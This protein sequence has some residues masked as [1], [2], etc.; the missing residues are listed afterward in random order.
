M[1]RR[2][3][4]AHVELEQPD[5]CLWR[6]RLHQ[7][8]SNFDFGASNIF[9]R[10]SNNAIQVGMLDQ[11]RIH[12]ADLSNSQMSELLNHVRSGAAGTD[13]PGAECGKPP[14]TVDAKCQ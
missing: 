5:R 6:Q 2:F 14:L 8:A 4:V 12:D 9:A 11:I 13:N 10:S 1:A 3:A 7:G